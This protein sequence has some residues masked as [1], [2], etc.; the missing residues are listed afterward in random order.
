VATTDPTL[1]AQQA[2]VSEPSETVVGR[3]PWELFWLR[4]KQDRAAIVGLSFVLVL[5]VLALCAPLISRWLIHHGPNDLFQEKMTSDIGIPYGPNKEFWFGADQIG[6]DVFIRVLY[7]ARTSLIVAFFST[8]IAMTVGIILGMLAGFFRG[9]LDTVISR[10][11]DIVLSM[12]LLVFAIGIAAACGIKGC[13]GGVVK[14]GLPLVIFIIAV[15]AWTYPARIIRGQTLS[16]RERE[17]IEAARASGAPTRR[18]LFREILPNLVA[19]IVIYSTILI[20]ANILFEA[21]LSFLGL[22]VPDTVAATW[23]NMIASAQQ[24]YQVAWWT[25]LFPGLM[26]LITTLAFNLLGDGLRD[27]LDPRTGRA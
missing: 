14:P 12:P 24:I 16:I 27:A 25:M 18:I 9:P 3:T 17:F 23:G 2:P 22:G 20:P 4:F 21:Y 26:L 11:V 5:V 8:G 7:G 6:R 13:L 15:F 1:L 10:F 19:P